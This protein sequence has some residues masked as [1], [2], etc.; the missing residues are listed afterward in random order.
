MWP[1]RL[2]AMVLVEA[3]V[4]SMPVSVRVFLAVWKGPLHLL[5]WVP[6]LVPL[7]S[8]QVSVQE[9]PVAWQEAL[10]KAAARGQS[11]LPVAAQ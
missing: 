2:L 3:A 4:S 8:M 9:A 10:L 1:P 6:S 7:A 11:S 5:A